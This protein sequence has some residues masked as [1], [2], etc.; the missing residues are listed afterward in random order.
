MRRV[1]TALIALGVV[2]LGYGAAIYL[3][4]DPVTDLYARWKQSQLSGGLQETFEEFRAVSAV[5]QL[6][7]LPTA[8]TEVPVP[9]GTDA[10]PQPLVDDAPSLEELVALAQEAV[11]RD[12][13]RL[14]ADL[15]LGQP[16]GRIVIPE[17]GVKPVVVH[18]TRW[19]QDLSRGPGHFPETSLPGLGSVTAIAGHRTTFGAWFRHIDDLE[20]GDAIELRLAYGTFRYEVVGHEIVDDEDWSVIDKRPYDTL[21]LSACHPLY[22]A[23]QRW[24]VYARLVAV[25]LPT[26]FSYDVP[27]PA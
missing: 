15:E 20:A 22:S 25:E 8:A 9:V 5:A 3:W 18:G 14:L 7:A 24:I 17:L 27:P 1:G 6:P 19:A 11:A 26:G 12:A 16:L 21:V 10:E 2:A 4:H 23:S 13:E